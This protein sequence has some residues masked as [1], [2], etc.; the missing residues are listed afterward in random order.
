MF[1]PAERKHK[2]HAMHNSPVGVVIIGRNEGDRLV[3]CIKDDN[4]VLALQISR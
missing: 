2:L 1:V 3:R 4:N